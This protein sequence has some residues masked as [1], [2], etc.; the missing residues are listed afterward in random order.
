MSARINI[1]SLIISIF[2][3]LSCLTAKKKVL[4]TARL[5]VLKSGEFTTLIEEHG[6]ISIYLIQTKNK[7]GQKYIG[8]ISFIDEK[9]LRYHVCDNQGC[10]KTQTTYKKV[11]FSDFVDFEEEETEV[12]CYSLNRMKD[13]IKLKKH[14]QTHLTSYNLQ[15]SSEYLLCWQTDANRYWSWMMEFTRNSP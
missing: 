15:Q 10:V 11:K 9:K 5:D 8:T 4:L 13:G 6:E 2:G 1:I 7:L 3:I 14:F 12:V